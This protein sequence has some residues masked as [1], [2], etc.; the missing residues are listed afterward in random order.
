MQSSDT[1]VQ[2]I[3]QEEFASYDS[4]NIDLARSNFSTAFIMAARVFGCTL[5]PW[6]KRSTACCDTPASRLS[7]RSGKRFARRINPG[8]EA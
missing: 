3:N 6:R 8:S 5:S 1:S 2:P 7:W 4:L